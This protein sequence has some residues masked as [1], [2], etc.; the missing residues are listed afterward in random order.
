MVCYPRIEKWK[1]RRNHVKRKIVSILFIMGGIKKI[2]ENVGGK[3]KRK[4][5]GPREPKGDS[6]SF[7]ISCLVPF[8]LFLVF[9]CCKYQQWRGKTS[10]TQVPI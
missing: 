1:G 8:T 7:I 10:H 6:D 3:V 4:A 5:E 9:L 2:K